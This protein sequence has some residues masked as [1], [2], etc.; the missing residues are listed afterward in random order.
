[1]KR[2]N[3]APANLGQAKN[4]AN[5]AYLEME[6]KGE[7]STGSEVASM[8]ANFSQDPG[9]NYAPL[10][11]GQL[12][13]LAKPFYDVMHSAEGFTIVLADGTVIQEQEYPWNPT[14]PLSENYAPANL[15]QLKY[16][17]SFSLADWP[18]SSDRDGDGM[19]DEWEQL[20]ISAGITDQNGDGVIDVADVTAGGDFDQDGLTNKEE[21]LA[22]TN[23][24]YEGPYI[25]Y[26]NGY[27]DLY[28]GF[29]YASFDNSNGWLWT[30]SLLFSM[31][32]EDDENWLIVNAN[33]GGSQ[34]EP[35]L[36]Q[37][38][39]G[40]AREVYVNF[41]LKADSA[42]NLPEIRIN[43]SVKVRFSDAGTI[44]VYNG[45]DSYPTG[46]EEGRWIQAGTL[47]GANQWHEFILH[48]DFNNHWVL[49]VDGFYVMG[50]FGYYREQVDKLATLAFISESGDS[51]LL[52]E[53]R[54]RDDDD[55]FEVVDQDGDGLI[56]IS[57]YGGEDIDGDGVLDDAED[58]DGDGHL[59]VAE[60][61]NGNG[62][63]DDGEDLD[64]DGNLDVAE[65]TDGDGHL[66]VAEEF[67]AYDSAYDSDFDMLGDYLDPD[68]SDGDNLGD[69]VPFPLKIVF[70]NYA[71]GSLDG[72]FKWSADE[73]VEVVAFG[74]SGSDSSYG[75]NSLITGE[76][77]AL[78]NTATYGVDTLYVNLHAKLNRRDL[79]GIVPD[80]G[81][82]YAFSPNESGYINAWVDGEWTVDSSDPLADGWH[83]WSI[84]IDFQART[85]SLSVDGVE[86][87]SQV[88]FINP[89]KRSLERILLTHCT[90]DYLSVAY[91][92][93][94][95]DRDG[96]GM[97]DVWEYVNFDDLYQR[98]NDDFDADGYTNLEE[99]AAGSDPID[100]D[101]NGDGL[102]DSL[103]IPTG[104]SFTEVLPFEED[105]EDFALG[106]PIDIGNVGTVSD[107]WNLEG[108]AQGTII[109]AIEHDGGS[110]QVLELSTTP[111]PGMIT[112]YFDLP[113][114]ESVWVDYYLKPVFLPSIP[115]APT[116]VNSIA[117]SYVADGD[118]GRLY[119]Y[120][121]KDGW[122]MADAD[123]VGVGEWV[124]IAIL[125]DIAGKVWSLYQNDK[126]VTHRRALSSFAPTFYV[127]AF[128]A[129][130]SGSVLLDDVSITQTRPL[131]LDDDADGLSNEEED[132]DG[133]GIV[134][135]EED[136]NGNGIL[137]LNEDLDGDGRMDV[138]EDANGNGVLD[139]GEDFDGDGHLDVDEDLNGD[140]VFWAS[141]DVD[142]DGRLDV[143][144][145]DPQN[146]DTDGDYI[147][148][149]DEL[150]QGSNPLSGS[151]TGDFARLP[152]KFGFDQTPLGAIDGIEG[153]H[154][155]GAVVVE[156]AN[157]SSNHYLSIG[158]GSSLTSA[159]HPL[160]PSTLSNDIYMTFKAMLRAADLSSIDVSTLDAGQANVVLALNGS[161]QLVAYDDYND[162]WLTTDTEIDFEAAWQT[163]KVY[164]NTFR[165]TWSLSVQDE[166]L[167]ENV[168]LRK[169][170]VPYL[171]YWS[172]YFAPLQSGDHILVDDIIISHE[173]NPDLGSTV[174]TLPV[175]QSFEGFE[176]GS[177][178]VEN[179][180]HW[181]LTGAGASATIV[182]TSDYDGDGSS[183]EL[184]AGT[185]PAKLSFAVEEAVGFITV[186]YALKPI[187]LATVPT[188]DKT[189]PADFYFDQSGALYLS[190]A[191]HW[192]KI[193]G[194]TFDVQSWYLF[195]FVYDI[196]A[197]TWRLDIDDQ[198]VAM[199][200]SV[201]GSMENYNAFGITHRSGI[202]LAIDT[203]SI[204][205][206]AP[207]LIEFEGIAT[208]SSGEAVLQRYFDSD[209][210]IYLNATVSDPDSSGFDQVTFY[211]MGGNLEN[212]H[213]YIFQ[214][215]ASV[216][217]YSSDWNNG[218][219]GDQVLY[220][221][222]S[223]DDG[224]E[225]ISSTIT[226]NFSEDGDGD[227][228]P[229]GWENDYLL[230]TG[231]S[232]GGSA[233]TDLDGYTD[234]EELTADSDPTDY[235]NVGHPT[236]AIIPTLTVVSGDGQGE[237]ESGVP[238]G[239]PIVI[240]MADASGNVLAN[241]PVYLSPQSVGALI[242]SDSGMSDGEAPF[243][244]T[245]D[246]NGEA[247]FYI[248]P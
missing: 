157:D 211:E 229:D 74:G 186:S 164:I 140:G 5:A 243:S 246:A 138:A 233:D 79:T 129:V 202:P 167:F 175:Y 142:R 184:A 99:Y 100:A 58:L 134:D 69:Y 248:Q 25:G 36:Y 173:E 200:L 52:D 161:G 206:G 21:F 32:N 128:D 193:E 34:D 35:R 150:A 133:D 113:E 148:D 227:G 38:F 68:T 162:A 30:E 28:D 149:G 215:E 106:D 181:K 93:L 209:T 217:V 85:W 54:V 56:L 90:V 112:H 195:R 136:I 84:K 127:W 95:V 55:Y 125:Q 111:G 143:A 210:R 13:A 37:E 177:D 220:A 244:A 187:L 194:T 168:P 33:G 214:G 119:Y 247:T 107:H 73:E 137:D 114:V 126:R 174:P 88:P 159:V 179:D 67:A 43:D 10:N 116:A 15:G 151:S 169:R 205:P 118:V 216:T 71:L 26:E 145:T 228:L 70:Q 40:G 3:Y 59:D 235:F 201:T 204:E 63:L 131:G 42:G 60:D 245:T 224:F 191:D 236:M 87:L 77:I 115:D 237:A 239:E 153:W 18:S 165:G 242:G 121:G 80:E 225:T 4:M 141:E 120:R 192:W 180:G 50:D 122:K 2:S 241:A 185:A 82:I 27:K 176:A 238:L 41:S 6:S 203:I 110:G 66:D 219:S 182:D 12:K 91:D 83:V 64:G 72:Q 108:D 14:M 44:E 46:G 218:P 48:V 199:G 160:V 198:T 47:N 53:V 226:V 61:A 212:V 124:R 20:I 197:N 231:V 45:Y 62:I 105:F 139:P 104:A 16:V 75:L 19:D 222:V 22:G 94:G 39:A 8:V 196:A 86:R 207:P 24:D 89:A 155:S 152:V 154:A 163:F 96:D 172:F 81:D 11:L 221:V 7:G 23:P 146:W 230:G 178:L 208:S 17:F 240:R 213:A 135:V 97:P 103:T 130:D 98:A 158:G 166:T 92:E 188:P 232:N 9:I 102:P 171:G 101:E 144:E 234:A 109:N 49:Y 183:L 147:S 65:D 132:V 1:M 123:P 156:D 78:L 117:V 189:F 190:N 57:D 31:G 223:D 29:D 76:G 170:G 51:Y